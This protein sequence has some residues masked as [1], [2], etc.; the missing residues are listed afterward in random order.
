MK[1][2]IDEV[3]HP[4]QTCGVPGRKIMY[5]LILLRDAVYYA[6]DCDMS[7]CVLNLDFE[8]AYDRISHEYMLKVLGKMGFSEKMIKWVSLLYKNI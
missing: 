7:L 6:R 8:K 2:V 3:I 1:E 5:S 4:D